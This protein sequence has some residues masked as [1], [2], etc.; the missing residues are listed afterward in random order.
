MHTLSGKRI[1]VWRR[2]HADD[3]DQIVVIANFSDFYSEAGGEYHVPGWP[4]TPGGRHW[5]EVTQDRDV[6]ADWVAREPLYPWE[7][8]VYTLA[9]P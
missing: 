1:L 4:S 3:V 7:A 6:P 9:R 5:H 8:K 2:G